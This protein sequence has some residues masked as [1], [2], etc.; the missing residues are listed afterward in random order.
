LLFTVPK[1]SFVEQTLSSYAVVF[2]VFDDM[3]PHHRDIV[4]LMALSIEEK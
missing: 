1:F 3:H 2:S 4:D